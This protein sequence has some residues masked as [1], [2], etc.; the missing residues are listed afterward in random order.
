MKI[1]IT[2]DVDSERVHEI[3]NIIDDIKMIEGIEGIGGESSENYTGIDF[4]LKN[5]I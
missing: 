1:V 4:K 2:I 5:M 3:N